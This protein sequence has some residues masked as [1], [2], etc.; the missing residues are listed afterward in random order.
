MIAYLDSSVV[1]RILLGQKHSWTGWARWDQAFSS[2]LLH[3]QCRRVIDRLRVESILDDAGVAHVGKE[4]RRVQ[5]SIGQIPLT[6]VVLHRAAL[7]MPTAVK[8]LDAIHL[9]SAL[10]LRERRHQDL[11][12]VTHDAQQARAAQAFGFSC[13]PE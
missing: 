10:L 11:V 9:A 7:P 1:I 13:Q 4:F 3:L 12:F 8:M 6:Q 2:A 5:R